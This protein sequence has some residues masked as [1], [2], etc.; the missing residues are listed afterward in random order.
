MNNMSFSSPEM[1]GP[2]PSVGDSV[3]SYLQQR[4]PIAGGLANMVFGNHN[5]NPAPAEQG[6]APPSTGLAPLSDYSNMVAMGGNKSQ[7]N[8]GLMTLLKLF[9]G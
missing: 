4:F 8:G 1:N 2:S 9:A 3:G 7:S 5:Q 6:A